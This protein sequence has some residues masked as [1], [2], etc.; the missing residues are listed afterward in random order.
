ML[1]QP[2]TW[3]RLDSKQI[4]D[5]RVFKVREDNSVRRTDGVEHTFFIIENPDWVNVIAFTKDEKVIL[6]EQFRHGIEEIT[7]ELPGGMVDARENADDAAKRE[8]LEE[9]G[10]AAN[11][12]IYLGKS[13]PNPALQ[14]N[15]IHHFLALACEKISKTKFDEHESINTK[16]ASTS[17]IDELIDNEQ[18]THSLVLAA[19]YKFMSKKNLYEKC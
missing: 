11:K 7:L 5:C 6:I 12:M 14:N 3:K 2:D 4:A 13:R 1:E 10:F 18:I 9:T 19:F 17:E 8:L 15:W 16:F